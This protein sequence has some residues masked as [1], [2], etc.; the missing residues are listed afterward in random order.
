M[1]NPSAIDVDINWEYNTRQKIARDL[2]WDL[3]MSSMF[4]PYFLLGCG[5][6]KGG[7]KLLAIDTPIAT[8]NGWTTMGDLC[9]GDK[10]F[11]VDGTPS[12]VTVVSPIS[13]GKQAYEII[14]SDGSRIIADAEHL[15]FTETLSD[16]EKLFKRTDEYR[17]KR[18]ITRPL[19]S[20]GKSPHTIVM[21]KARKYNYQEPQKGSIH[22]TKQI[23]DTLKRRR[24]GACNHAVRCC[25]PLELPRT[26]LPIDPYIL[27]VW[28]GDGTTISGTITQ[29]LE[30]VAVI[31][32]AHDRWTGKMVQNKSRKKGKT[33]C[34]HGLTTALKELG[35]LGNKHIPSIYLRASKE[36]RLEL[37]RGLLDTDGGIENKGQIGFT[38]TSIGIRDGMLELLSTMGIKAIANERRAT[39][40]GEDY[41]PKWTFKFLTNLPVFTLP[42]KANAQ[43]RVG[44]NG[45]HRRRYIIDVRPISPIPMRCISIDHPSH[46]YLA[47]RSLIPTHNSI[48]LDRLPMEYCWWAI[49]EFDIQPQEN[50]IPIVWMGRYESTDFNDTTLETFLRFV[51]QDQYVLRE[52]AKEIVIQDR[53]M[54]KY[55]GLRESQQQKHK[56][57]SGEYGLILVDQ[58]EEVP[59]D[60]VMM[61]LSTLRKQINGRP[62]P[63]IGVFS[64]NPADVWLYSYFVTNERL[65]YADRVPWR[66]FI[67]FLPKDN[68]YLPP[69]YISNLEAS[70]GHRPELLAAYRDGIWETMSGFNAFISYAHVSKAVGHIALNNPNWR[71]TSCDTAWTGED[72]TMTYNWIG[73]CISDV[74]IIGKGD[75]ITTAADIL[76]MA[77]QN[78]STHIYIG[79]DA[80]GF[81]VITELRRLVKDMTVIGIQEGGAARD[82]DRYINARAEM[83]DHAGKLFQQEKVGIPD[84]DYLKQQLSWT[85]YE[86]GSKGRIKA[87]GKE[88]I[89]ALHGRSPDRADACILGLYGMEISPPPLDKPVGGRNYYRQRQERGVNWALR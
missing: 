35:V 21:N 10:V 58:A 29:C 84:D 19:R 79:E 53:V 62:L 17:K 6:A 78:Q 23:L 87:R 40:Y 45:V 30:D 82:E 67:K 60:L 54:I 24:D 32:R 57:H 42:R 28:L 1:S 12:T 2:F 4:E 74:S 8:P 14:F 48:L 65:P 26:Y 70:F 88:D 13:Y 41:G 76:R 59:R 47:G 16:R 61:L 86:F 49:K 64:F 63:Y 36:Q 5:G 31:N 11:A 81:A 80:F 38:T 50:P 27:G 33:W 68:E 52:H 39:L 66:R 37:L 43:K 51:P 3:G 34:F 77:N 9:I 85:T 73:R 44:F 18:R 25:E 72:E 83:H 22:T 20:T 55:G 7:G 71:V 89:K 46:L 75:H 69:G 56:F 15:W